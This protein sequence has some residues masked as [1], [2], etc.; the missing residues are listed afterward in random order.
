MYINW[1]YSLS[2]LFRLLCNDVLV[3]ADCSILL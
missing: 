3:C 1:K 2:S